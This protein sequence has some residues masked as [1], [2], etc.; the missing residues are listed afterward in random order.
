MIAKCCVIYVLLLS[1]EQWER[2]DHEAD[3]LIGDM[4]TQLDCQEAAAKL[5]L[6]KGSIKKAYC[7]Y[8]GNPYHWIVPPYDWPQPVIEYLS[9]PELLRRSGQQ[10]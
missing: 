2:Y 3:A 7:V 9:I 10:R 1:G 5:Y 6:R 4:P 8:L